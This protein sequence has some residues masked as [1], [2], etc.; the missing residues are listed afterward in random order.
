MTS[1]GK[2]SN[3]RPNFELQV[4]PANKSQFASISPERGFADFLFAHVSLFVLVV[5]KSNQF[6]HQ[7]ILHL[8]VVNFIG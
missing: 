7:V 1:P 6:L 2:V 8:I 5:G 4:N 3:S